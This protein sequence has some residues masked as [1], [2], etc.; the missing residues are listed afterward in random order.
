MPTFKTMK[1]LY[2][3]VQDR[4]ED[5]LYDEVATGVKRIITE[6]V[7]DNVYNVADKPP[8]APTHYRRRGFSYDS[9]GLGSP[10]S[11][12]SYVIKNGTTLIVVNNALPQNEPEMAPLAENI[13][14]G[15]DGK[16]KWYNKPRP[17]ISTAGHLI[18]DNEL[19]IIWMER[20]LTKRRFKVVRTY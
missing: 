4:V 16:D 5:T 10:G 9:G 19:H 8:N 14:Y 13:E 12:S 3:Y 18:K 7:K 15:Y 1:D 6:E 20:G 11:M 17:F 2:K